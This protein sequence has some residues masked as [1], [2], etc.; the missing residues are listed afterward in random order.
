MPVF[1]PK[2]IPMIIKATVLLP[3]GLD[4]AVGAA[5]SWGERRPQKSGLV[6]VL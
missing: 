6:G 3:G 4:S 5:V 1:I 2:H